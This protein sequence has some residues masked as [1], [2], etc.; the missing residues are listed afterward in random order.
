MPL[1]RVNWHS[2]WQPLVLCDKV[3]RLR[4]P[5]VI[6]ATSRENCESLDKKMLYS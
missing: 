2:V 4:L 3:R 1:I 5:E 6:I